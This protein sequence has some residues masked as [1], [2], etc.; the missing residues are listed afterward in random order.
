MSHEKMHIALAGQPNC[1]KSTIFNMLTGGRQFVANYPGATV[2][3]KTGSFTWQNR[4]T[5][6]T[7]LPG[8]YSLSSYSEEER[9][10]RDY[11]LEQTPSLVVNVV[12][13]SNL[14]RHLYLTFQLLEIG[15]PLLIALNMV[16][17]AEKRGL[18]IDAD[19]FAKALNI[20]V[21][22]TVG[23]KGQGKKELKDSILE[24]SSTVRKQ[25]S[26]DVFEVDY[27]VLAPYLD[28]LSL[29][30][31]EAIRESFFKVP[32]R[33]LA[34]KLLEED[35][36]AK[37]IVLN[38]CSDPEKVLT[39]VESVVED[40]E[41]KHDDTPRGFIAFRRHIA[42][43]KIEKS[44]V[45]R[46]KEVSV[47]LTDRID[48]LVCS[49]IWGPLILAGI[50]YLLYELSIV[51]GY[52]LTN[53]MIPFLEGFRNAVEVFLPTGSFF[54]EPL[55]RI[56]VLNVITSINSVLIYIPIFLVLFA[57]I[58]V[59]EDVGYMPR[60]AFILDKLFRRFGLHGQSTLPLILGGVFVGGCAVPGVMATRVIADE[61]ARLATIL[62][63][64]LMNCLAKVPLY[65]LLVSI[66]FAKEK[67]TA[68]FFISTIT[69]ILALSVAKILTLTLLK[70]RPSSPFVLEMPPYHIPT[71]RGVVVRSVE[72]TW[73]FVKKVITIIMIVA[74]VV[75][76]LTNYPSLNEERKSDYRNRAEQINVSFLSRIEGTPFYEQLRSESN[77][78]RYLAVE[79]RYKNQK[80][81]LLNASDARKEKFE[82]K[83]EERYPD[84]YP[85]LNAK[86][87]GGKAFSKAF[88]Q[89]KRDRAILLMEM[90]DETLH[91]SFLGITG[92]ALEP[93]TR[94]AGFNWK[95]NVALLSSLA[96]KE[97][98]VAT[99]GMLY[100][101]REEGQTLEESMKEQEAGFTS[102]HAL[103]LMIFMAMYPPCIAALLMVKVEA[104]GWK[105]AFI[106]L[107]Y[108][109]ILGTVLATIVYT[110]GMFLGLTGKQAMF[111]FY[112]LV[113]LTAFLL[114]KIKGTVFDEYTDEGL[115]GKEVID[116]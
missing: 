8:T 70:N 68:M 86:G 27:G 4:K 28:D 7:D 54:Q 88:K 46:T 34:I 90:K 113:L 50:I 38:N 112:G 84:A 44:C 14:K 58:A 85:L 65:T 66:Y 98:S 102:L 25:E 33:W 92:K 109:I 111:V 110:G 80:R 45:I 20:P 30:L 55:I 115:L 39:F 62:V 40:F 94:F 10:A 53:Y 48:R 101:P 78:V 13:A 81:V 105:W 93:I 51:Q 69:I 114:G 83:F 2:S 22:T 87:K 60:M 74:V 37:K 71:V 23:N 18:K 26:K 21:V 11:I 16:D 116:A 52:K 61:K 79:E 103:A 107:G 3:I 35:E 104:G 12:D 99:L 64:P 96:A 6:L 56:L 73:L 100:Q 108:P 77:I 72:R 36:V 19:A 17:V 42:A 67:A 59:L 9:I 57:L 29:R 32:F 1:G 82:K 43:E 15:A 31:E 89:M 91:K 49:R 95:V 106:A 5:L 75:F 76:F 63:V 41:K 47:T 24:A 97:S